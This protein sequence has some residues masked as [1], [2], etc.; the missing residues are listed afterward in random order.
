MADEIRDD[1]LA[2]LMEALGGARRRARQDAA[3]KVALMAHDDAHRM[4]DH[5]DALVDALYRPEAQT[6]WEIFDALGELVRIDPAAV[7]SGYDGAEASLFD[8][9]SATVRLAAFK[10]LCGL[11]AS[12]SDRSDRVWPLLDEAV[13]CYHGDP[14]YHDMLVALLEFAGGELSDAAREALVG[15]IS[16]DAE[17]GRSYIKAYS[18]QIVAAAKGGR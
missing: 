17:N 18:A 15:R 10:F 3:H 2:E 6:R 13:Q 4:L 8:E 1:E 14:E 7:E 9:G 16:F 5:V 12:S 11:G